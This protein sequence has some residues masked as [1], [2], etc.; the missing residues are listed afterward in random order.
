MTT[1]RSSPSS[2]L[3][4]IQTTSRRSTNICVD[5]ARVLSEGKVVGWFQGRSEFGPRALGNRSI[6]A[7]PRKA[8]MKDILNNRVKHRQAFRPFAPI[9]LYERANEIFEGDEDSPYM[10]LAKPVRP[11][12]RDKI[13]AVVHVDG[14]ARVQTVRR[15]TNELLYRLLEEFEAI[16]GVPV[17]V[18]TSF[19]VQGEPIIEAPEHAA[20]CF[21]T[22]GIDYLVLHDRLIAK[23]Q[24][25]RLLSP[26]VT[27]YLEVDA[28]VRRGLEGG[29]ND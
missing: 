15:E 5:T 24:L 27:T 28:L 7:D 11:Q 1:S 12:W 4:R 14:T 19:N 22:T 25:H 26:I 3:F 13:P 16:T 29:R 10:L 23:N 9:V 18:N 21:L 20:E 6:L 8:E 17:L 2:R